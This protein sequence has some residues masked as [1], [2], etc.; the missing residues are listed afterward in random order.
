MEIK[1]TASVMKHQSSS[2]TSA[3]KEREE[4]VSCRKRGAVPDGLYPNPAH[5]QLRSLVILVQVSFS[6]ML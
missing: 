5:M 3:S 4:S 6:L 1:T 2:T